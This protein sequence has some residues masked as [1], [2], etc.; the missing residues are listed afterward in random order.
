M[1]ILSF[2]QSDWTDVSRIYKEGINTG[3]A[4]FETK[5]PVWEQWNQTH[6]QSCRLKA[7]LNNE[8]VGWAALA[9]TSKREVYKGVAEVSI[10][11]TSKYRN[12][13]IGKL[14]L[15]K[16][17]EDSEQEGFW[18]LQAGIFS[19]NTASI[20]LHTS[21]GFRIIGYREKVGKLQETWYDNTIL[22]RRSKKIM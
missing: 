10:Y 15:T 11:I 20:Q 8:I 5:V 12:L 14:L 19:N 3:I 4:T 22:E 16:L 17:I 13:G 9:P 6:I 7:V 2:D 1:K 18:T 21:L